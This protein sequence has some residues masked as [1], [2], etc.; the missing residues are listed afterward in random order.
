[1][2]LQPMA[3]NASTMATFTATMIALTVDDSDVPL[4][5][6]RVRI[7]TMNSAGMFMMPCAPVP[8]SVSNGEWHQAYGILPPHNLFKYSLQAIETVP[9]PNAYSSRGPTD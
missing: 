6:S 4:I 7:R 9:A 5:S 1:M 8:I 3:M 2:K